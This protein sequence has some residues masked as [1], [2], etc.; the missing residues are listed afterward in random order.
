MEPSASGSLPRPAREA[1][2]EANGGCCT[3]CSSGVAEGIDHVIPTS[4]GGRDDVTNIVPACR[5]CN[6]SKRDRTVR[7]WK[8]DIHA[9]PSRGAWLWTNGP[10][11]HDPDMVTELET[12]T[13][14]KHVAE[15]QA[16]VAENFQPHELQAALLALNDLNR[17][18]A[19][20]G[21]L[22]PKRRALIRR[23]AQLRL[24]DHEDIL[25]AEPNQRRQELWNEDVRQSDLKRRLRDL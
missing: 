7:Q 16:E 6:S 23:E 14:T 11:Y 12:D 8:R 22:S 2:L 9:R 10:D 24:L 21:N 4:E 17:F 25:L 13:L 3:Y 1:A 15:V 18:I 20:L 5:S 19:R